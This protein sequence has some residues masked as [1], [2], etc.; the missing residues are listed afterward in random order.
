[1]AE[2]GEEIKNPQNFNIHEMSKRSL[3]IHLYL[4]ENYGIPKNGN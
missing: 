1:M 2:N 4:M 3:K